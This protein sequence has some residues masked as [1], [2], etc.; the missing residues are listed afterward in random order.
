MSTNI[1]LQKSC[2]ECAQHFIAKTLTTRFCS[3]KCNSRYNKTIYQQQKLKINIA[4]QINISSPA[5]TLK[6]IGNEC[7]KVTE[8]AAIMRVSRRTLF[9]LISERKLKAKK[10]MGR[11]V[12]LKEDIK[13]FF[14]IQ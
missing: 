13:A 1:S 14:Q 8:A 11:T 9:R 5:E 10:V 3:R 4:Q 2:E 12:I 7:L 6:G